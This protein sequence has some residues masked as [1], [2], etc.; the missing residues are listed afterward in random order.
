VAN[1]K[2]GNEVLRFLHYRFLGIGSS[3]AAPTTR[4]PIM[5]PIVADIKYRSA[6][7]TGCGAVSPANA[8]LVESL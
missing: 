5:M 4:M 2:R 7:E 3:T 6:A 8:F 1:K